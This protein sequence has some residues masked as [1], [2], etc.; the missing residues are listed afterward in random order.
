MTCDLFIILL[1]YIII[2]Y[3]YYLVYGTGFRF[4]CCMWSNRFNRWRWSFVLC[5]ILVVNLW[6]VC[7]IS[8]AKDKSCTRSYRKANRDS[9]SIALLR[10][11]P[12][13]S[14]AIFSY[15][16]LYNCGHTCSMRFTA[17]GR[18]TVKMSA[19][20]VKTVQDKDLG[21]IMPFS[22]GFFFFVLPHVRGAYT[23]Q[24]TIYFT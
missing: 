12:L 23:I 15:C 14:I 3:L 24:N 2:I 16:Q 18:L 21:M 9:R 7:T 11:A 13:T 19:D 22:F 6:R 5:L 17:L 8:L 10:R 1:Q 20:R 4:G